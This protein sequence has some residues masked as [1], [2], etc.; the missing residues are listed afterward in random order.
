MVR[1]LVLGGFLLAAGLGAAQTQESKGGPVGTWKGESH[2]TV[3][4]SSCQE[5]TV[6]YYISRASTGAKL[7]MKANKVVDGEEV[8]MGDLECAWADPSHTLTCEMP[9]GTWSFTVSGDSMAGTLK[10]TDG[11]LFRKVSVTRAK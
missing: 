2:C 5:E 3:K 9:R 10:L 11:T 4:P 1:E 6:V 8:S 7:V